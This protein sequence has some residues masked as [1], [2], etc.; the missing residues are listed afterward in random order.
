[1]RVIH[2]EGERPVMAGEDNDS[3]VIQRR[4]GPHGDAERRLPR[5]SNEDA[6]ASNRDLSHEERVE[7]VDAYLREMASKGIWSA[8]E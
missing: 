3:A 1:M 7:R 2:T 5:E 6:F 8:I 4:G